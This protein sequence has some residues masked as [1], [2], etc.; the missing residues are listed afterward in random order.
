MDVRVRFPR[1]ATMLLTAQADLQ[2]VLAA[3][4]DGRIHCFLTKPWNSHELRCRL[5]ELTGT[6]G[7][8]AGARTAAIQR[9]EASLHDETAPERDPSG[10]FVIGPPRS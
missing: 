7:P 8:G 5:A 10:A 3:I 4:N 9:I 1:M 2:L 6:A